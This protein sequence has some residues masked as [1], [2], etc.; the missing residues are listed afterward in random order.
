VD[1]FENV[2]VEKAGKVSW[3]KLEHLAVED[4]VG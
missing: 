4:R 3:T 1:A 2:N